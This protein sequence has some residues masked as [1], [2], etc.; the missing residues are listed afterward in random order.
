MPVEIARGSRLGR[1]SS[2]IDGER[3]KRRVEVLSARERDL[4]RA[5]DRKPEAPEVERYPLQH[6][7]THELECLWWLAVWAVSCRL[8]NW[9]EVC[10]IFIPYNA[11]G[12][13]DTRFAFLGGED[14]PLFGAFGRS[15]PNNLEGVFE[16]LEKT[17]CY[18]A[19]RYFE[20]AVLDKEKIA[21]PREH[22]YAYVNLHRLVNVRIPPDAPPL[23]KTSNPLWKVVEG[24][25]EGDSE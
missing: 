20:L 11:G 16:W 24:V 7:F 3:K 15:L 10:N 5:A 17:R 12:A 19:L 4:L 2:S 1:T 21:D 13:V 8:G 25:S 18:L 22:S 9:R 6:H 14:S 23:V